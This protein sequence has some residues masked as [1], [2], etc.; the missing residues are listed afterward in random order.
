[1]AGAEGKERGSGARLLAIAAVLDGASRE[2]AFSGV[3]KPA[4]AGREG[5]RLRLF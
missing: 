3:G 4:Q 2:E 5:R 1:V